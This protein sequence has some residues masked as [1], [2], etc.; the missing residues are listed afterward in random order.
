VS[1]LY[2]CYNSTFHP[3]NFCKGIIEPIEKE[4]DCIR[5]IG[6][7]DVVFAVMTAILLPIMVIM[8]INF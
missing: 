5:K 1:S 4:L 2:L 8:N 3:K 6:S 7:K